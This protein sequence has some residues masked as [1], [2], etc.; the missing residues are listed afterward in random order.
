MMMTKRA[1]FSTVGSETDRDRRARKRELGEAN[2]AS[3]HKPT[4]RF[5]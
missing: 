2:G 1:E 5:W 4:E 3:Q